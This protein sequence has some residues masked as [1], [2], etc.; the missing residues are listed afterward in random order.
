MYFARLAGLVVPAAGGARRWR[1]PSAAVAADAQVAASA[2]IREFVSIGAGAVI[3]ERV[4][5][6]AGTAR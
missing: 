1:A 4:L 3:G 2:E 5:L 6:M